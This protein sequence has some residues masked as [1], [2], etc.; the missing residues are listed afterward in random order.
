MSVKFA[1]FA[2]LAA[3]GTVLVASEPAVSAGGARFAP[4]PRIALPPIARHPGFFRPSLRSEFAHSGPARAFRNPRPLVHIPP[5]ARGYA[6]TTP[7]RPY[8]TTGSH[9]PF[10]TTT[11]ERPFAHLTRRHH[12]IY[13]SGWSF[14]VTF[15]GDAY[16]GYYIGTPYDPAEAFPVYG[17][18]PAD[19]PV[20][21]PPARAPAMSRAAGA[22]QGEACR[23]EQVSV[24]S[25]EGERTITVVRC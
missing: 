18:A 11:L 2:L 15:G 25:S 3:T 8:A 19:D 20:D 1:A 21:P 16:P 17:P 22:A 14:P 24:P 4:A 7:A 6:T 23:S 13:H 5:S 12:R 10:A 9:R